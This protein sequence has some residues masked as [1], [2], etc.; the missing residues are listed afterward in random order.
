MAGEPTDWFE[1]VEYSLL[2]VNRWQCLGE[3]WSISQRAEC[4]KQAEAQTTAALE[5]QLAPG[6]S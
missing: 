6:T 1:P 5:N 2:V 4:D 3:K